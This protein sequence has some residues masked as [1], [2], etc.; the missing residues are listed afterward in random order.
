[1]KK[2]QFLLTVIICVI[3][4]AA[5][6]LHTGFWGST[7]YKGVIRVG[8]VYSEDERVFEGRVISFHIDGDKLSITLK[9]KKN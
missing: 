8:F 9:K 5:A 2:K 3:V 1:M 7:Q 4:L 6:T